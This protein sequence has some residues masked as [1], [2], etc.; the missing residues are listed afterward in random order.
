M[1]TARTRNA[2]ASHPCP[3]KQVQAQCAH[4]L[5]ILNR[6][7]THTRTNASVCL[8]GR[9]HK[10]YRQTTYFDHIAS[11]SGQVCESPNGKV[12][13]VINGFCSIPITVLWPARLIGRSIS[14]PAASQ[15]AVHH[16]NYKYGARNFHAAK[17][18]THYRGSRLSGSAV[19]GFTGICI[20]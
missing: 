4:V 10:N 19:S 13:V 6:T 9:A 7:H 8:F 5:D 2:R 1:V 14:Q 11:T 12:I 16:Y 20:G 3:R 17:L 18:S 15:P